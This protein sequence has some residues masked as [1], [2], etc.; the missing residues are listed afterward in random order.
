MSGNLCIIPARGGSKRIPRKNIKTFFGRPIIEY[1]IHTAINSGLFDEV[2]VSTDDAEIAS[3]A[4]TS[5]A[6]V[7]FL[8]SQEVAND[9]SSTLDVLK[10]VLRCYADRGVLFSRIC[11]LYPVAPL[12]TSRH[13]RTG[14]DLMVEKGADCV[15]PGI[16]Y[17]HPPQ[18][19]LEIEDGFDKYVSPAF[20]NERTQDL[21]SRY[22]DSGQWYWLDVDRVRA[23]KSIG[24]MQFKILP[25]SE[26]ES[27][28][29]DDF[30]DWVMLELKF[31]L[32][33]GQLSNEQ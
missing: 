3:I 18:R 28:D 13:L 26:L 32:K 4:Q 31:Q 17:G 20:V 19:A 21:K 11:C 5:G 14:L 22:H 30:D 8:R 29:V 2:M 12:V 33:M 7:P 27:Q 16:K 15:F 6:A 23:F 24:E 1:S 25:L 9:W 10:E